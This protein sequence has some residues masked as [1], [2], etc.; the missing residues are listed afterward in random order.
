MEGGNGNIFDNVFMG[1]GNSKE[2]KQPTMSRTRLQMHAPA[3]LETDHVKPDFGFS[4]GTCKAAATP[5]PL[6][7]PLALSPHPFPQ[8]DDMKAAAEPVRTAFAW[9]EPVGGG[10]P[11]VDAS[12]LF[13]LFQTRCVLVNDA[14]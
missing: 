2:G 5:I 4:A 6:L 8:S 1:M 10:A 9:K 3:S 11:Y 12:T 7:T 14:Q 13:A